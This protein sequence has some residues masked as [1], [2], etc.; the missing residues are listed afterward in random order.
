MKKAVARNIYTHEFMTNAANQTYTLPF[1][2]F[3]QTRLIVFNNNKE[4]ISPVAINGNTL[5]MA[6]KGT[7]RVVYVIEEENEDLRNAV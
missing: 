6:V 7:Y 2:I 1:G 5:T 3:D 4:S